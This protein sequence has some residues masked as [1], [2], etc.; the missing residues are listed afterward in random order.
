MGKEVEGCRLERCGLSERVRRLQCV[1]DSIARARVGAHWPLQNLIIEKTLIILKKTV[2]E[3][4]QND[5][6]MPA[7][8]F[9]NTSKR[10]AL[11]REDLPNTLRVTKTRNSHVVDQR[12]PDKTV[13]NSCMTSQ[14]D[15]VL[16]LASRC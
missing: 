9:G 8:P 2:V 14:V 6:V 12:N 1:Q 7:Q 10:M 5:D 11:E 15:F 16:P 3:P 4:A 13:M